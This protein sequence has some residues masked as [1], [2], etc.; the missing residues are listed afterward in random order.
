MFHPGRAVL[1]TPSTSLNRDRPLSKRE[2]LSTPIDVA[3]RTTNQ[4]REFNQP[5]EIT[6]TITRRARVTVH[7]ENARFARSGALCCYASLALAI[8]HCAKKCTL[9]S[10][11][12]SINR[13][14]L[15][16]GIDIAPLSSTR[17]AHVAT[18]RSG[19]ILFNSGCA[20]M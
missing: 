19:I 17:N 16:R 6:L 3:R 9:F 12:S 5:A 20:T 10:S 15:F 11:P 7:F 13:A 14:I 8:S 2:R 18:V 4:K 1:A